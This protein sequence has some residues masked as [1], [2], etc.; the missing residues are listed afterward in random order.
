MNYPDGTEIKVGDRVLLLNGD[1]AT[2]VFSVDSNRYSSDSAKEDWEYLKEGIM[3]RTDKGALVHLK[4]PNNN[5]V[6]QL[7][8]T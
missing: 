8:Y 7:S 1:K 2:V 5:D 4:S 3:V 6:L